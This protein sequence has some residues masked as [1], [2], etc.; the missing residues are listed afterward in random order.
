MSYYALK[1]NF[2][3]ILKI[4]LTFWSKEIKWTYTA[5]I[6]KRNTD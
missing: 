1:L 2:I 6:N 3:S 4:F 5:I